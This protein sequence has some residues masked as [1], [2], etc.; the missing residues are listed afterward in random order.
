MDSSKIKI[1]FTDIDMTLYSHHTKQV[2]PSAVDAIKKL[3]AKGIK[4]FLCS[5]RNYYL[6]RKNW[7]I[8]YCPS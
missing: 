4:V 1:V 2:P 7:N 5:G 8:R 3:Q 6:I